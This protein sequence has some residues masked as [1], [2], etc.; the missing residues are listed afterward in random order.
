MSKVI[1]NDTT[2]GY[3]LAAIN[4]NFDLIADALNN[5]V[6]YRI[7]P[8]GEANQIG[9]DLDFNGNNALNIA[10][11]H[12]TKLFLGG[13]DVTLGISDNNVIAQQAAASA[14]SAANS[15]ALALQ[16]AQQAQTAT[17]PDGAITTA[18]LAASSVTLDKLDPAV[19]ASFGLADGAVTTVKLAA[20][21]V[22]AAKLGSNS[23]N[24][25]NLVD[26]SV[27]QAKL[28]ALSVGTGN[29]IDASVVG[30]K[31]ADNSVSVNKI[32]NTA[33][34]D[35]K[36]DPNGAVY[37][38]V[39]RQVFVTDP[40]YAGGMFPG[41]GS[42]A[43]CARN[44]AAFQAIISY[45]G[46]D[47][48]EIVFPVGDFY[49]DDQFFW[50][51]APIKIS[52]QGIGSSRIMMTGANKICLAATYNGVFVHGT[53]A[54]ATFE[55]QDIAI[56][57]VAGVNNNIAIYASWP[58][59]TSD[60]PWFVLNNVSIYT[61]G[62][63]SNYW[64]KGIFLQNCNGSR[65][66]N[67]YFRGDITASAIGG[68][69]NPYS[70]LMAIHYFNNP[71]T[72]NGLIDHFLSN[73][74]GGSTQTYL[75]FDGWHEGVYINRGELTYV[76]NCIVVNGNPATQNPNLF[77]SQVHGN[78]RTSYL[79]A[80]NVANIWFSQCDVYR[81]GGYT[82]GG[83]TS[84]ISLT[85]CPQF[86]MV[87]GKVHNARSDTGSNGILL[88]SGCSKWSV[89]DVRFIGNSVGTALS[90]NGSTNTQGASGGNQFYSWSTGVFDTGSQNYHA[91]DNV[92]WSVG[93]KYNVTGAGCR[94]PS[95]PSF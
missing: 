84:F 69:V 45:L 6:L 59:A 92:F 28:A 2:S 31:L 87:G 90:I 29:L 68:T 46:S 70:S 44:R 81:D 64:N 26:G 76:T 11:V 94:V 51:D 13:V 66:N 80:S 22:T 40:Q 48:G 10:T 12:I 14:L 72:T 86:E 30:G 3:N 93:T 55:I 7:N 4:S 18:K 78:F 39:A 21:A 33:V 57:T 62:N 77:V 82:G 91:D 89:K 49:T 74:S 95:S 52:G 65:I 25:V 47:G 50:A 32:V 35:A 38:R 67:F 15:A 54:S 36:L 24:T 60:I 16:Y 71:G 27:L 1:L 34:V 53:N 73:L 9:Q 17:I 20:G 63:A 56:C 5:K 23:V 75:Q 79:T 41:D 58:T 85:A 88:N 43:G 19:V 37:G 8:P 42:L 83:N 61:D